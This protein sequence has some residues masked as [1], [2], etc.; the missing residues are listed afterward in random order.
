MQSV[1]FRAPRQNPV[2]TGSPSPRARTVNAKRWV[3]NAQAES[4]FPYGD[5]S[6]LTG[7]PSPRAR[8]VNAKRW[9]RSAQA[10]SRFGG[11]AKSPRADGQCKAMG[12]ERPG[13]VPFPLR[14]CSAIDRESKSLHATVNAK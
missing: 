1:G 13:S 9:I 12:S 11:E 6:R 2:L 10:E 5:A 8:T 3:Q 4:R 7:S 14:G